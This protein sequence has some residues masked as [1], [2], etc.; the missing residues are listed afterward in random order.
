MSSRVSPPRRVAFDLLIR[1]RQNPELHSDE[2]LRSA[3]VEALTP[4]DRNLATTLVMGVLRWEIALEQRISAALTRS[5]TQ[6]PEALMVTLELGALQLL[7]LDR[8]PAHAAIFESVELA[9][10]TGN[11]HAAGMVNAVLRKLTKSSR[12]IAALGKPASADALANA[13]AHPAWMVR[14]W[15]GFYGLPVTASICRFNQF[16]PPMTI[17]L[18]SPDAEQ[19]LQEEGV[20]ME[21]ACFVTRARHVLQ[22]DLIRSR[23]FRERIVRVQDEGSQLI[24]ELAGQGK[25]ILD[26]CAAPG[27]KTAILAERNP[28]SPITAVDISP[29]RVKTMRNLLRQQKGTENITFRTMDSTEETLPELFD[30]IL[31]DAPCSGTGTLARNPE[32][33]HRL[34]ISDLERQ[35]RRQVKLLGSAMK[36]LVPGGRLVYSTCSLEAEENENVVQEALAG[37][38]GFQLLPCRATMESLEMQSILKKGS[39]DSLLSQGQGVDGSFL[40]TL[41]GVQPFDGFFGALIVRKHRD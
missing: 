10:E 36:S 6:L 12:L 20:E 8:I 5:G 29:N 17:R 15:T 22:G 30:L 1:L 16:P 40:R 26:L 31:C 34:T 39:A 28:A 41:P 33:R 21:E 27:G 35:H 11:A 3:P 19:A 37:K 4:L 24:A 18:L 13:T 14:R 7:L 23:A 25:N 9:K 38:D 32:I 2:V